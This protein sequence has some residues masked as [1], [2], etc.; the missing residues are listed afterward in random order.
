MQDGRNDSV[1]KK[2]KLPAH[3][4]SV[5]AKRGSRTAKSPSKSKSEEIVDLSDE[6]LRGGDSFF[7]E[8]EINN[9]KST[10]QPESDS[11]SE[12]ENVD[13][14]RLRQGKA[15][16]AKITRKSHQDPDE[17]GSEEEMDMD[18]ITNRVAEDA[19]RSSLGG[20]Y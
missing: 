7:A 10:N 6:E 11:G 18:T 1:F 8:S 17:S 14:A 15:Y 13:E 20:V 2:P 4:S 5:S 16:L 19:V 12:E 9:R 3:S